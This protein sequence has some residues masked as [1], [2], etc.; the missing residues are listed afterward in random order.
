MDASYEVISPTLTGQSRS[1]AA[2]TRGRLGTAA[3]EGATADEARSRFGP[4]RAGLDGTVKMV[5]Q[6]PS[7]CM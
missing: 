3:R 6:S 2:R 1:A 5:G 7:G 4:R